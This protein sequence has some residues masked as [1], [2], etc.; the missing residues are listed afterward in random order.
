MNFQAET[1]YTYTTK[2]TEM[3]YSNFVSLTCSELLLA[4]AN[5]E[6]PTDLEAALAVRLDEVLQ[7]LEDYEPDVRTRYVGDA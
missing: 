1:D 2:G 6:D 7:Q 4:F 5:K 3:R